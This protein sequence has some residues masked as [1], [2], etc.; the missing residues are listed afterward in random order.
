MMDPISSEPL[1]RALYSPYPTFRTVA[2]L[3]VFPLRGRLAVQ[4]ARTASRCAT[5]SPIMVSA[6]QR[7]AL[8]QN[9]TLP[10]VFF[11]SYNFYN[12]P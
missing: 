5:T 12:K 4:W 1:S 3:R 6:P 7:P 10:T 8:H 11:T 9:N 2:R